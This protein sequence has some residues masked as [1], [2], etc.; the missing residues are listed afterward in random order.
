LS[1]CDAAYDRTANALA[2]KTPSPVYKQIHSQKEHY[3]IGYSQITLIR[4]CF[5]HK[6]ITPK[7]SPPAAP[8]QQICDISIEFFF[9]SLAMYLN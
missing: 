8:A 1:F 2:I 5:L 6:T 9:T 7:P 3:E 4:I